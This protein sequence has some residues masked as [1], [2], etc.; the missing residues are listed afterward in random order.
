MR[1]VPAGR[2]RLPPPGRLSILM[3]ARSRRLIRCVCTSRTH[4]SGLTTAVWS[5]CAK[6]IN[7]NTINTM[8][9]YV[10][11]AFSDVPTNLRIARVCLIQRK[12]GSIAQRRL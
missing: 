7:R 8:N 4:V 12:Y 3:L 5:A 9:F 6:R 2:N 1:I 11:I 10:R